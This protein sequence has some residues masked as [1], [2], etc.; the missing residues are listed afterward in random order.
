MI[1]VDV[2]DQERVT[3]FT[4]RRDLREI[5]SDDPNPSSD[6]LPDDVEE[7]LDSGDLIGPQVDEFSGAV[8]TW[9]SPLNVIAAFIDAAEMVGAS[10]TYFECTDVDEID[11]V[12]WEGP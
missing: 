11:D 5:T 12:A 2:T 4:V 1:V 7:L 3:R 10:V 8:G 9:D 6:T